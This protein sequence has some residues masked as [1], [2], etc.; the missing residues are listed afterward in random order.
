MRLTL[1]TDYSLRMLIYLAIKREGLSTVEEI[2]EAYNISRNHLTKVAHRLGRAGFIETIRGRS[3]GLR[4]SREPRDIRLI[5]VVQATEED[6]RVVECFDKDH[7]R[8]RIS[9]PCRLTG[10]LNEALMAW[11]GVLAKYTLADIAE[12]AGQLAR[13]LDIPAKVDS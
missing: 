2:A 11:S 8:C 9:G 4:L 7:N 1:Y 10:V 5:D 13:R 3:G 12:P 6:F